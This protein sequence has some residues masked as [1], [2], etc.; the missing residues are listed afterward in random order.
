MDI[1]GTVYNILNP[2]QIGIQAGASA[3]KEVLPEPEWILTPYASDRMKQTDPAGYAQLVKDYERLQANTTAAY[4]QA[5]NPI[6]AITDMG[7]YIL[8][9]VVAFAVV[10]LIAKKGK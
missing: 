1:F 9:G 2:A 4:Q 6:P 7:K 5:L 10:Y 8:I 3:A